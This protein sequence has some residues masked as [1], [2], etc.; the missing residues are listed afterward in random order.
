MPLYGCAAPGHSGLDEH[1]ERFEQ[2][3]ELSGMTLPAS[4]VPSFAREWR[5][6]CVRT[7]ARKS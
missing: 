5:R 1:L 3:A 4:A 2:S 7:P 6:R